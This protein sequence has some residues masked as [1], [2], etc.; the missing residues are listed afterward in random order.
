[1]TGHGKMSPSDKWKDVYYLQCYQLAKQGMADRQIAKA[2][3]VS[4]PTFWNWKQRKPAL[5]KALLEA[6][7]KKESGVVTF[8]EYVYD[9]LKP[10]LKKVWDRILGV[11]DSHPN[12][13][14]K[15]E[16]ILSNGG[17]PI[18]Q[19]LFLHALITCNFQLSKACKLVNVSKK[20]FDRWLTQD[21]DFASLFEEID[22]YKGNFFEAALI[23]G[24]DEGNPMLVKYANETFNSKRGYGKQVKHTYDGE[25]KHT[26]GVTLDELNLTLE[27]RKMLLNKYRQ[28]TQ[29]AIG[30]AKEDVEEA[31]VISVN[32]KKVRK[33]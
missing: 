21:P 30:P 1:M 19:H 5:T 28:A 2:L 29:K 13:V 4:V 8:N 15:V 16:R 24:V 32:G 23:K 18:R 31:E 7:D 6:R 3:G 26:H 11:W 14:R 9:N 27:E 12:P 22:W 10:R 17:T 20:T 25:V 33:K